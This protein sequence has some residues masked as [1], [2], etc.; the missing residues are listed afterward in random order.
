MPNVLIVDQSEAVCTVCGLILGELGFSTV[1]AANTLDVLARCQAAMPDVVIVD[2][3]L[4]GAF[5]L[6]SALRML[7]N[8]QSL[9]IFC[10]I[11]K[12]DLR[13]LMAAKNAGATDVLLKPFDRKALAAVF[14]RLSISAAA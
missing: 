1:E 10:S 11:A 4:D 12:A 9:T 3:G 14:S 5:E 6:I 13:T 7:P 2:A 8:S